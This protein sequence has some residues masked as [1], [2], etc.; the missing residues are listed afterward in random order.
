MQYENKQ[1]FVGAGCRCI[2]S[3]RHKA[4][5]PMYCPYQLQI[6]QRPSASIHNLL[7]TSS[8]AFA[9]S[10]LFTRQSTL[11]TKL[12]TV[13]SSSHVS[14]TISLGNQQST[15][16]Q[17]TSTAAHAS[18]SMTAFVVLITICLCGVIFTVII[19]VIR[20]FKKRRHGHGHYIPLRQHFVEPLAV[21][22]FSVS[23]TGFDEDEL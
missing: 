9:E 21:S 17:Y 1:L 2:S 18:S 8:P 5:F 6:V 3:Q 14:Q 19:F 15:T 20:R 16:S 4:D 7:T 11:S 10:T 12:F 22:H 13:P 23:K